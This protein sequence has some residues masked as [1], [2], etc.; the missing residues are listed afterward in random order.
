MMR[1]ISPF[2]F[3]GLKSRPLPRR[4]KVRVYRAGCGCICGRIS[5]TKASWK[6]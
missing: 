5:P 3:T 6:T 4:G 1:V 2:E